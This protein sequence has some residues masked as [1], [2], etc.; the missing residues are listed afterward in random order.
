MKSRGF[1]QRERLRYKFTFYWTHKG[2][3]QAKVGAVELP[4]DNS[5]VGHR[6]LGGWTLLALWWVKLF[7][8]PCLP[9]LQKV[10]E[11]MKRD[12]MQEPI[13][14]PATTRKGVFLLL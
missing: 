5:P 7:V 9:P 1:L 6:S 8:Q 10:R 2:S 4:P 13:W 3:T 11:G 12:V 14:L